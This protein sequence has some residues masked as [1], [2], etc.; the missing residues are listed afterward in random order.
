MACTQPATPCTQPATPCT[1]PATP[2]TQPATP[3]AQSLVAADKEKKRRL[4][5]QELE[6]ELQYQKEQKRLGS[7]VAAKS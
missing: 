2:C 5:E 1:Q 6:R 3:C 7:K 4:W